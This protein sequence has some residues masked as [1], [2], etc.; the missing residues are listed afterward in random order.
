MDRWLIDGWRKKGRYKDMTC[1]KYRTNPFFHED[2]RENQE[3]GFWENLK[4]TK[5][6]KTQ[7]G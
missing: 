4:T 5:D 7:F 6:T 2:E 1:G 3:R